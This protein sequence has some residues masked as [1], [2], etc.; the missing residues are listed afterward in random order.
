MRSTG[1]W[2][3]GLVAFAPLAL[4]ACDDPAP[5]LDDKVRVAKVVSCTEALGS[6]APSGSKREQ[7]CECT[8]ARLATEQ[9]TLADL[10][11]AK[12]D[13]AMEQL[14]WCLAQV[15]LG[16]KAQTALPDESETEDAAPESDPASATPEAATPEATATAVE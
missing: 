13:R 5:G 9:L 1:L 8:T 14:R 3:T 6:F 2:M 7:L 12:R 15:G 16:P 4:A 11:G 10:A